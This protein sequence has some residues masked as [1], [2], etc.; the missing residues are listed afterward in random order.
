MSKFLV[1]K[2]V[3]YYIFPNMTHFIVVTLFTILCTITM[4]NCQSGTITLYDGYKLTGKQ[5]DKQFQLHVDLNNLICFFCNITT[6][7][8]SKPLKI[9]GNSCRWLSDKWNNRAR[10]MVLN[11]KCVDL[12]ARKDCGGKPVRITNSSNLYNI[13]VSAYRGCTA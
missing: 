1:E 2:T 10:S 6:G 4:V 13:M 3:L 12:Y 9:I 7:V 8:N 11:G 5:Y